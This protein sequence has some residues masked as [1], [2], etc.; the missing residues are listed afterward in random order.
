VSPKSFAVLSLLT[1]A[2]LFAALTMIAGDR[3]EGLAAGEGEAAIPGLLQ[4]ANDAGKIII[5]HADGKITLTSGPA[6]WTV[7][8]GS[9]YAARTV[10]IKRSV[11][12]LAQLTLSEPKTRLERK[13]AKLE[14]LDPTTKGANSKRVRLFDKAGKSIGDIIVGKRRPS[15]AGTTGGGLYV[16]RPGEDQ[17]WLAAGDADIS[18]DIVDWLEQKI[19]HLDSNRVKHVAIRHP[20]GETV[21][22]AKAAPE[23]SLFALY[24][25]PKGKKLISET[26]PTT[27][28][29]ALENLVLDDVKK[30]ADADPFD[31]AKTITID[32]TT[33]DGL[34][35]RVRLFKQGDAYGLTIE[36]SGDHEDVATITQRTKG[37]VYRIA[38]YTAS[39]FTRRMKDLVEDAKPKS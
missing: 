3:G 30:E 11:L 23:E 22:V 31:P 32:F 4:K 36:A 9:G 5:E 17:T 38:D 18:K 7:K 15:L 14:L 16:R 35:V 27:I 21:N 10:K 24:S 29:G 8:E 19:V 12:G 20:D 2:A 1:A 25:M 6:G 33:F 39:T 37:W 26:E 28:G 34:M 13:F